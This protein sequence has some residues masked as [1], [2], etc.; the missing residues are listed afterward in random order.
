VPTGTNAVGLEAAASADPKIV[1]L[2]SG[3]T[4]VKVVAIPGRMVNFVIKK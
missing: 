2:L 4:I 1:S 3:K